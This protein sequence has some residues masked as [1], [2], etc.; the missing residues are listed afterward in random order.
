MHLNPLAHVL[1]CQG[2]AAELSSIGNKRSPDTH[3]SCGVCACVSVCSSST[4]STSFYEFIP[5]LF[6]SSIE[7]KNIHRGQSADVMSLLSSV[8]FNMPR[9]SF[10]VA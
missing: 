7:T 8:G 4:M 1:I 6:G 9:L 2:G 3:E 5:A 10:L